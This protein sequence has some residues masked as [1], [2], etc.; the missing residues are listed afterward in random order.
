MLI[1][2]KSSYLTFSAYLAKLTREEPF[3]YT[4]AILGRLVKTLIRDDNYFRQKE[5]NLPVLIQ[6]QLSEKQNVF[7]YVFS[8]FL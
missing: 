5:V 3:S 8:T 7:S 2:Q 4:S 6:I 1:L